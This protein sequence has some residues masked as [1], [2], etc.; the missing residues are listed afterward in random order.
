[1]THVALV[2]LVALQQKATAPGEFRSHATIHSIGIEWDLQGDANHDAACTV[3]YRAAGAPAWKDALPLF[4]VDYSG[5]YAET[6]ADR[7]YNMLAGSILFLEPGTSYEVKLDLADPDGGSTAKTLEIRTRPVPALREDARTLHVVPGAGGG[8][9][10]KADPFKGLAAA[11]AAAKPGDLFLVGPGEYGAFAFNR[12]GEPG[13]Y[14]AW[15]GAGEAVFTTL[16]AAASH[17]W[18]EGLTLRK[19]ERDIALK[20]RGAVTDVVLTRNT[21][22]GYQYSIVMSKE[23]FDCHIADNVIEG[24]EDPL[25][26]DLSGEGVELNHSSGHVVCHNRI[27]RVADGVSYCQRNCDIYGNDIF[28]VSDDG[29]EPDY[30]YANNRMWG[31]RLTNC[32]NAA[33][34]FQPMYCGPW[35]F[36]RNEIVGAGQVFKFRV[37]DRFVL[38]NNTF[39]SWGHAS[40]YMHHILTSLSRN[41]LYIHAGPREGRDPD[42]IWLALYYKDSGKYVLPPVYT[43]GWMT[44]VDYDGFDWGETKQPFA[45]ESGK[46]RFN[47]LP[48]FAEGVGIEKHGIR[49]R[50]EDIFENYSLPGRPARVEPFDLALKAGSNAIDAGVPIPNLVETFAGKAPDLGAHE[51]GRP[52]HY[53]PRPR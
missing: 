33:L 16:D 3:R 27:S 45:W 44:D 10:S 12:P 8:D 21:F 22:L 47:D 23:S 32:K 37:Q 39:V 49:V 4:R 52:V 34:S 31:N 29:L 35:Y 26:G 48:S 36:I 17:V 30:G 53:G 38:A 5:W 19:A 25:K 9:G 2:L 11:Q 20:A 43:P 1:M 13:K 46:R 6:L 41:N 15:K 14:I 28:D 40:P 24:S 42:P 7:A 18:L 50:K 51:L